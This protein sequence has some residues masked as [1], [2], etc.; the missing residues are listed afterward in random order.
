MLFKKKIS[1]YLRLKLII[2]SSICIPEDS[3]HLVAL[4]TLVNGYDGL[5]GTVYEWIVVMLPCCCWYVCIAL[6]TL[7]IYYIMNSNIYS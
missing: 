4:W 7:V 1:R 2:G 6:N 3:L 5:G